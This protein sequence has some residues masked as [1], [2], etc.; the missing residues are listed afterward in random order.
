MLIIFGTIRSKETSYQ[1]Y[2]CPSVK[3][4]T[5]PPASQV[6]GDFNSY[7]TM[8]DLVPNEELKEKVLPVPYI[9]T[10]YVGIRKIKLIAGLASLS[11]LLVLMARIHDIC[12]DPNFQLPLALMFFLICLPILFQMSTH[13]IGVIELFD[14]RCR[15]EKERCLTTGIRVSLALLSLGLEAARMVGIFVPVK[16]HDSVMESLCTWEGSNMFNSIQWNAFVVAPS[17]LLVIIP[18]VEFFI[19][20]LCPRYL[21]EQQRSMRD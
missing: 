20:F 6:H 2:G 14:F 11:L 15:E 16:P 17:A 4:E 10:G 21:S 5:D 9:K 1:N 18:I 8:V 12:S 7:G 19:G 13:I 3:P